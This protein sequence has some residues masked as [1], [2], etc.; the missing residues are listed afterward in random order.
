MKNGKKGN[1]G[2]DARENCNFEDRSRGDKQPK[3]G[4][5]FAKGDSRSKTMTGG[6]KQGGNRGGEY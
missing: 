6:L 5:K 1:P 3:I 4:G 2:A